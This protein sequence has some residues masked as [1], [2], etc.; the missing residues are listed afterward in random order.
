MHVCVCVCVCV[1]LCLFVSVRACF[2]VH[3]ISEM[4]GRVSDMS[5]T[6]CRRG[7]RRRPKHVQ[8]LICFLLLLLVGFSDFFLYVDNSEYVIV[9]V[10]TC[11][12]FVF[13]LF[14]VIIRYSLLICCFYYCARL[15]MMICYD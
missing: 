9:F 10:I 8:A 1:R 14:F 6:D 5:R 3:G 4:L 11:I 15:F 7:A 2:T 13:F 12:C